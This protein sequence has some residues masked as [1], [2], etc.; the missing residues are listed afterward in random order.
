MRRPSTWKRATD[1]SMVG[2]R[3]DL[4]L[5]RPTGKRRE[6]NIISTNQTC[7]T[8]RVGPRTTKTHMGTR[9][10][11]RRNLFGTQDIH[12][13]PKTLRATWCDRKSLP[14]AILFEASSRNY[15]DRQARRAMPI[16]IL[17]SNR[18][19]VSIM[20]GRIRQIRLNRIF[21]L[22]KTESCRYVPSY[23]EMKGRER[24]LRGRNARG[25]GKI[26][27]KPKG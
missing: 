24:Q 14:L 8:K 11:T 9:T 17:L 10:M 13:S 16:F 18:A 26:E 19:G 23:T 12:D 20:M 6:E 1:G 22:R 4:R 7:W 21:C 2:N 15:L 3:V 27:P 5:S 25:T